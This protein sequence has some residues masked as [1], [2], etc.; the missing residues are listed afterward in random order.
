MNLPNPTWYRSIVLLA[1]TPAAGYHGLLKTVLLKQHIHC[2][3]FFHGTVILSV[4]FQVVT[5]MGAHTI[6]MAEKSNSGFDG[7][8]TPGEESVFNVTYYEAMIDP[9]LKWINEVII[10][11]P[12]YAYLSVKVPQI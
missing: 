12:D 10:L 11:S 2:W 5:I 6:G 9:S 3:N 1:R 8:W 7:Y 4:F